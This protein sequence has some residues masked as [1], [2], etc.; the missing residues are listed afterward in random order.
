MNN[1]QHTGKVLTLADVKT[2]EYCV[3]VRVMGH[4]GF[5]HRLMEMGFV[6]GEKVKVIRNAP[7]RDPIEYEIMGGHVSLRR[8]E[9]EHVEVVPVTE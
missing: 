1:D 5:R 4:G 9:A 8:I 6:R 3:I 7:L 2:G